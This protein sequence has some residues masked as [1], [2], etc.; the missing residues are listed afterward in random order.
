VLILSYR[1][2]GGVVIPE[3]GSDTCGADPTDDGG[4]CETA[5]PCA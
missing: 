3:P 1:F 5:Q 4:N 2:L